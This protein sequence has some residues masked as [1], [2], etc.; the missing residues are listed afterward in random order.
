MAE[1]PVSTHPEDSCLAEIVSLRT[2]VESPVRDGGVVA[3]E[4]FTPVI[5]FAAGQE[6]IRH[7][8]QRLTLVRMTP[9]FIDDQV[10]DLQR[11]GCPCPRRTGR[12]RVLHF[13]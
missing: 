11:A 10:T 8:R 12:R 7:R 9:D 3:L 4:G 5:P 13:Y 2:V 6:I 1:S